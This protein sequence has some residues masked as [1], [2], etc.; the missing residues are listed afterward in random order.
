[1]VANIAK[2]WIQKL[3]EEEAKKA[4]EVVGQGHSQNVLQVIGCRCFQKTAQAD[5]FF[6][7]NE[8]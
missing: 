4:E 8:C 2:A 6:F 7:F 1:M 5:T 3:R